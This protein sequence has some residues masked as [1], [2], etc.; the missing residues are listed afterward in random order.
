MTVD[1]LFSSLGI[2][3]RIANSPLVTGIA[4]KVMEKVKQDILNLYFKKIKE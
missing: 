2:S 4:A 1:T 3:A